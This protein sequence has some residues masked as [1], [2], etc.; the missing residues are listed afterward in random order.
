[1][2]DYNP[3]PRNEFMKKFKVKLESSINP[4]IDS[5]NPSPEECLLDLVSKQLKVSMKSFIIIVV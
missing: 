4:M 1:M 2:D 3:F 5:A